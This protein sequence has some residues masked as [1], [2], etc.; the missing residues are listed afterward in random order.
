LNNDP[1]SP[2]RSLVFG[3]ILTVSA[4]SFAFCASLLHDRG[5]IFYENDPLGYYIYL[6]SLVHD[7]DL[8]FSNELNFFKQSDRPVGAG[9][10]E[11]DPITHRFNN[12][13]TIGLPVLVSPFYLAGN[14]AARSIYPDSSALSHFP[15]FWDQIFFCCGGLLL[16]I[17]GIW[18]S[19][20]F[21][22]CF[23]PQRTAL[24]ATFIFWACSPLLYYLNREPFSSHLGS[25]FA[26]SLFLYL[27][28]KPDMAPN[29]RAFLVGISAALVVLVR[30]QDVVVL[31]F[32]IAYSLLSGSIK[33]EK[34]RIAAMIGLFI[35]GFAV[36]F[37]PQMILW[38]ILR[39]SYLTYSYPSNEKF[40]YA[41]SPRIWQT[42]FSS[43]HG[44]LIWHPIIALS[45]LGLVGSSEIPRAVKIAALLSFIAQLYVVASWYHW[46][47]GYSFGNR[48]FIGISPIFILGVAGVIQKLSGQLLFRKFL[49]LTSILFVWNVL[50]ALS[51]LSEMIP[52][53]GEFSWLRLFKHL[54]ELPWRIVEKIQHH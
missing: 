19:F 10:G 52:Y 14:I 17:G 23:F 46:W 20:Q 37:I 49:I 13:Y 9:I 4:V 38:K 41:F 48:A 3:I 29:L 11:I 51:Y 54:P 40:I 39:G 27:C 34:R 45:I 42:L 31:L 12:K 24:W 1:A 25:I 16:G 30:Q 22:A 53:E 21:A 32:P 50:L 18:F 7:Q 15:W 35:A 2:S 5:T 26:I 43:N 8:D 6:R 33:L 36:V 47:M 44:L 28:I